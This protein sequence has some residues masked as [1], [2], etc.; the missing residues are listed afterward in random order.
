MPY[1]FIFPVIQFLIPALYIIL[2]GSVE[3]ILKIVVLSWNYPPTVPA[4]TSYTLLNRAPM[5]I[6]LKAGD[7]TEKQF[8]SL[9]ITALPS[10]GE[11]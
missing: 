9:Q 5:T 1:H 6:N 7:L 3:T 4:H 8:I 11:E 2:L 10:K